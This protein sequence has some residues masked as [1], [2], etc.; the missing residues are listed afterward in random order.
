MDS[1]KNLTRRV[2]LQ[3]VGATGACLG[4]GCS[5][6]NIDV[7]VLTEDFVVTLSEQPDLAQVDKSVLIDAGTLRPIAVTRTSDTEFIVTATECDHASCGVTRSGTGWVCPCH[8]SRFDLDGVRTK[9]PAHGGLFVYDWALDGD[10]LTIFA[11]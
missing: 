8:G 2:F 10:V 9:G 4:A 6:S 5:D 7:D 3:V 11:P 1:S